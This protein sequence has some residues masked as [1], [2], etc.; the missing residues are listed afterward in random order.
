MTLRGLIVVFLP[1][2]LLISSCKKDLLHWS[3]VQQLNS[4][5]TTRLNHIRFLGDNICIIA[6]GVEFA[7]SEIVVSGDGGY[8]WSATSRSDAPKEMF[9]MGTS[10]NG[11]VYLSG[12]DGD[13]LYSNDSGATWKFNR[14][15][16][17][18]VYVGGYFPTHD[19]GIFV[20]TILQRSCTVTRIDSKFNIIDEQN[21]LFGVNNV[22]P[23]G[24]RTSYL[25]GYGTVMK[26]ADNGNNWQFQD[27]VGDNFTAMDIHGDELWLCGYNGSIFHSMNGGEKWTRMRNGNDITLPRYYL[28]DIV[29]KDALN[30]WAVCDDGRVIHTDDGGSHWMEYDR[31]STSSLRSIAICP[32]GDLLMCGD[33]G[34]IYR[35]SAP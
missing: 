22:Y 5:T 32:N 13:I 25:I 34:G 15:G 8:T 4:N 31:F 20:S 21:H 11:N 24:P 26:T 23:A 7:Q 30:G 3:K 16:N 10:A 35:L 6:G 17:W 33:N 9:G 2:F 18:N 1:A 27:V 12:V 29:F 28:M 14:I 19:T